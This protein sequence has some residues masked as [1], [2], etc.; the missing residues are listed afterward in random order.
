MVSLLF[1]SYVV[2]QNFLKASNA[3]PMTGLNHVN[4][5][6][7]GMLDFRFSCFLGHSKIFMDSADLI[8][9]SNSGGI[10]RYSKEVCFYLRILSDIVN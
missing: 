9:N 2:S 10:W 7:I 1:I 6:R 4:R 8:R 5:E 3:F